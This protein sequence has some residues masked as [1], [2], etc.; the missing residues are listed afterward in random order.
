MNATWR[1]IFGRCIDKYGY[2]NESSEVQQEEESDNP[3]EIMKDKWLTIFE[4]N[5]EIEKTWEPE[6]ESHMIGQN[7]NDTD[8]KIRR[9][10]RITENRRNS[11]GNEVEELQLQDLE[12]N[13]KKV[14]IRK[15]LWWWY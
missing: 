12:D 2:N 4:L 9:K 5:E 14:L 1:Y 13:S 7:A 11:N 10:D 3:I 6:M 15:W 8:E